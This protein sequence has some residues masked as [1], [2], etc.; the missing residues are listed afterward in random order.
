MCIRDSKSDDAFEGAL[1]SWKAIARYDDEL[2]RLVDFI[3]QL[4]RYGKPIFWIEH[5][6]R[7]SAPLYFVSFH[8]KGK[9]NDMHAITS[10]GADI[11]EE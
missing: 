6:N 10:G 8:G 7:T 9:K 5:P 11:V 2:A 3:H 4:F 1:T